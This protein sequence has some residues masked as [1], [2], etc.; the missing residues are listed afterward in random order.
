MTLPLLLS[1]PHAGTWIPPEVKDICVLTEEEI[2]KDGDEGAAEIYLPLKDHVQA[3]V[4]TEVSRAV[5]DMNR[6]LDDRKKD[7]IVK[8]HTCWDVPVYSGILSEERVEA[9]IYHYYIPYHTRLT[10]CSEG[11]V[12]GVD[13]HT[14]A[15][16][17]PPVAPDPDMERPVVCLSND[18][19]TCSQVWLES[20]A[21][22]FETTFKKEVRINDPFRGGYII[23]TH[24]KE[25]PWVQLEISRAPFLSNQEKFQ[26]VLESLTR[27]QEKNDDRIS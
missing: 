8:T 20:L 10:E 9:L 25:V 6:S 16:I 26:L 21:E 3:L 23:R 4:T 27:W 24:A 14:M 13:C 2:I 19:F 18:D 7:G 17:A 1:V 22:S 12:L 15:A 11:A 5:L